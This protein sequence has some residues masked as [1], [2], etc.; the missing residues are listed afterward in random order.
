MVSPVKAVADRAV[1]DR[2]VADRAVSRLIPRRGFP[3]VEAKV[4]AKVEAPMTLAAVWPRLVL[5]PLPVVAAL[6]V[7]GPV[8]DV[9]LP[10]CGNS[11]GVAT[12]AVA[13][14]EEDSNRGIDLIPSPF[15]S[16]ILVG[17]Q[18]FSASIPSLQDTVNDVSVDVSKPKIST[19][20]FVG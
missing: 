19:L 2:A 4:E 5:G 12:M 18:A 1:A 3:W 7:L 6:P 11:T 8:V 10:N 16:K 9:A 14:T 13:I 15:P 17:I 20:I